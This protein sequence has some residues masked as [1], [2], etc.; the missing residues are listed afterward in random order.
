[1]RVLQV[2]THVNIG[3]IANYILTLSE[4]LMAKDVGVVVASSGGNLEEELRSRKI[5]HKLLNIKTKF[6]F[7]PRVIRSA[8]RLAQI[9]KDEKIDIIHAHTRVSQVASILASRF[10]GVP[11]VTTCHGYF[12]LRA[13]RIFDTWGK[14]VIAISD[15]VKDHLRYDFDVD[16]DRIS[17]IYNGIDAGR[18][19]RHYS[20]QEKAG[21]R[22]TLGLKDAPVIGTIGR[23]SQVKGQKYLVQAIADV[24]DRKKDV[25]CLIVGD[26]DQ[27]LALENLARAL[28]IKDS[29]HIVPSGLGTPEFLAVMDIFV[30]P[31][32]KE[33]L[34]IALLE[35]MAAG[36]ACVA[37]EIGGISDIIKDPSYGILVPVGDVKAIADSIIML[38][39]NKTLRQ[40][41]GEDAR[42]LVCEKFSL[43][44]MAGRIIELYKGA[45]DAR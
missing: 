28:N 21:I 12:K 31:S 30:F 39:D 2:T 9:I 38:L 41:M 27:R 24:I 22:N 35:A 10:T 29:V 1:M 26:G 15:A 43:D 19:T 45:L 42:R 37:S 25:Q 33:G 40:N 11:Y 16:K 6:E 32:V 20:E 14:K 36:K 17:V 34:G 23:L 4:A 3:G 44:V 7:G 8:F 18:F 5:P 13:R